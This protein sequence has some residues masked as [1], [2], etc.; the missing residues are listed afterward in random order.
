MRCQWEHL[1]GILEEKHP[2]L[3]EQVKRKLRFLEVLT[4]VEQVD[5]YE[6]QVSDTGTAVQPYPVRL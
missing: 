5:Q 3:A 1:I 2:P 6:M 4:L